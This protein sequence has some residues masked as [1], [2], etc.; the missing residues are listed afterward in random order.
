M[1]FYSH[2]INLQ[3]WQHAEV[4]KGS[5]HTI[6][7]FQQPTLQHAPKL[8]HTLKL[9]A[10]HPYTLKLAFLYVSSNTINPFND[11]NI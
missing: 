6:L 8:P 5:E 10:K 11:S 3:E 9:P 2:T 4:D 7:Q 1:E